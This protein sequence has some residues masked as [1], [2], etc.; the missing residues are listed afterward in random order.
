MADYELSFEGRVAIV[1]GAGGGLGRTYA[2]D[3][4]RRGARVVVNDFGGA[5][6]GTGSS[7]SPAEKVVEEIKAQGGEAL[8]NFD[9][10]ALSEG[11]ENIVKTALDAYGKVDI[12]VNNAGILRDKSFLKMEPDSWDTVMAVHLKGAFCVTRPAFKVMKENQYGRIVMTTSAAG[13]YGNFGQ[14]NYGAA[15]MGLV[16]LMNV[17]K[18]EGIKY[19]IKVNSIAPTAGSRMTEDLMPPDFFEKVKPE[20]VTPMVVYLCS[21]QCAETGNIYNAG[22]GIFSRVAIVTGPSSRVDDGKEFATAEDVKNN[23]DKI[24]SL[25]GAKTYNNLSEP[26]GDAMAALGGK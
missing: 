17:L 11:G 25:E 14:S 19:D 26:M 21:E 2:L 13:L 4:A 20:F 8:P 3:L 23:M 12:V 15:K 7:S 9:N 10:V 24:N 16:G 1:T 6:D 5:R 22:L 18:Q